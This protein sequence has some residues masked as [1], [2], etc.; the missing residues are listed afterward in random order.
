MKKILKFLLW[1]ILGIS[2]V[3]YFY[4]LFFTNYSQTN[5]KEIEFI[6]LLVLPCLSIYI[7]S[8]CDNDDKNKKNYL[9]CYLITYTIILLG[10]VFSENR[11]TTAISYGLIDNNNNFVPFSSIIEMIKSPLGIKFG[12]YNII[13]NFFMLTPF[14]LLLPLLFDNFKNKKKFIVFIMLLALS[15]ELLQFVTKLGSFD[16]DDIILNTL[17]A[18]IFFYIFNYSK[19]NKIVRFIFFKAHINEK[20]VFIISI[21]LA[22]V[23]LFLLIKHIYNVKSYT[24]SQKVDIYNL[25]CK[26]NKKTY[27]ATLGN[28]DYYTLCDYK[29]VK[30][31]R[32]NNIYNLK[33]AIEKIGLENDL[34][35]KIHFIKE[36]IITDIKVSSK[37]NFRE[38]IYSEEEYRLYT[39]LY[40][41]DNITFKYKDEKANIR[42]AL[43]EKKI[44]IGNISAL[45]EPYKKYN[46]YAVSK[47][48]YFDILN[49]NMG[50]DSIEKESNSYIIPKNFTNYEK[51]CNIN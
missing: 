51:L 33:D 26:E 23:S 29:D 17:G 50:F 28:Y 16:I 40:G 3:I 15:I 35:N 49:C 36:K 8:L 10:F 2:L 38:L 22:L 4:T 19:V 7:Y 46:D 30:V 45:T 34:N 43:Q 47:G 48:K 25:T 31:K 37:E 11:S 24:D 44:T 20:V 41:I 5:K 18:I 9:K 27:V 32:G 14:S 13:G 12:M 39:Y 6:Y 21:L 42:E 1:I